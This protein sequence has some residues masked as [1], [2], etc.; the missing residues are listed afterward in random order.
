[1]TEILERLVAAGI[2]LL[3]APEVAT[4]FIFTRDGFVA[5]VE[6]RGNAFGGIGSAGLLVDQGLAP[7]VRRGSKAFFV[8]RGFER[9]A[10]AEEIQKLQQFSADL[11]QALG[12]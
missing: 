7:L 9:E 11:K 5:L 8:A 2:E 12:Y 1:M 10:S 4:H 6:R 3:P